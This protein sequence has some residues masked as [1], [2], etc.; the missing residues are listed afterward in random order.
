MS[1]LDLEALEQ[2]ALQ[3]DPCD[4]IV[5]PGFVKADAL[6]AINRDY[7]QIDLPGNFEP[8]GLTYGPAFREMLQELDSPQLKEQYEEKFGISLGDYP[9]QMTIRKYSEA[10][11]GNIHNDSRG[12]II[13]TLIYFNDEWH[14]EGGRLRL[15]RSPRDIEDYT[16]EVTPAGGTMI[17]FRRSET[18]YHGFKRCVGERRSLQMYWVKPKRAMRGDKKSPSVKKRLKRLFKAI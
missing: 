2:A 6:E 14:H 12:K 16:A 10:S 5:V 8:E 11:D 15:L 7:P 1:T 3:H 13:T 17:A 4:F 18:S 9:L